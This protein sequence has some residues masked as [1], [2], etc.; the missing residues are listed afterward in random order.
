MVYND[1]LIRE[2]CLIIM[3]LDVQCRPHVFN[4][5]GNMGSQAN[6]NGGNT[7]E[8]YTRMDNKH[9]TAAEAF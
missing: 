4:N 9:V 8:Y 2:K 3:I 1:I 5:S 7:R 6:G